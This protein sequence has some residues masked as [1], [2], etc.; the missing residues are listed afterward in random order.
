[1]NENHYT[2]GEVGLQEEKF[3]WLKKRVKSME[4]ADIYNN[5]EQFRYADRAMTCATWLQ[6]AVIGDKKNLCSANFCQLRLCPMCMARKASKNAWKLNMVMNKIDHKKYKFLFLTLTM[7]N[8]SGD[9]LGKSISLLT[10]SW[11]RLREQ[12]PIERA[13]V[14]SF[15]AVEITRN[16]RTGEYHPHLHCIL[17]VPMEYGKKSND[18][19]IPHEEWVSRWRNALRVDYDP[20]VRITKTKKGKGA[21]YEAAKYTTKDSEYISPYLTIDQASEIVDTYTTALRRKRLTAFGG[22]MKDIAKELEVDNLEDDQDLVHIDQDSMRDDL[23]DLILTFNW[24]FGAGDY[25]L[26]DVLNL[27]GESQNG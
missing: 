5:L 20:S 9:D 6:F 10:K 23:A 12:R 2:I 11:R 26:M 1:M 22:L 18:L 8:C 14:G 16:F 24:H 27:K 15:R 4:L 19:Y 7:K 3:E 21:V 25:V 13:V 17:C